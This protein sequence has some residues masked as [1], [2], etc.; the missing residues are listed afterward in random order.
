M[1][2]EEQIN[3][4]KLA[5]DFNLKHLSTKSV[6]GNV[7]QVTKHILIANGVDEETM[8]LGPTSGKRRRRPKRK[9]V[10]NSSVN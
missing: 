2:A 10:F 7:S 6:P 5:D 1:E 9:Y 8:N 4:K 3:L